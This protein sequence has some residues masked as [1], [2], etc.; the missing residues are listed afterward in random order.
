MSQLTTNTATIDEL[1][2]IANNL[3]DAGGSSEGGIQ[4]EIVTIPSGVDFIN[5]TY[6]LPRVTGA[7]G[8]ANY[9]EDFHS[10]GAV[11]GIFN[12]NFNH[13]SHLS[14]SAYGN[15]VNVETGSDYITYSNGVMSAY[16]SY[17]TLN[18]IQVMLINDPSCEALL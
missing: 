14:Y 8:S 3:P 4:Y 5:I 6:S 16:L 7:Y 17:T 15:V 13:I 18:S 1:I 10:E 9:L 11:L 12:N 2:T